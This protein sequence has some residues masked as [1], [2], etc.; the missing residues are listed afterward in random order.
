M[1]TSRHADSGLSLIEI[2]VGVSIFTLVFLTLVSSFLALATFGERNRLR[3]EALLLANEEIEKI[4]ALPYDSIG[5]VA[6]LPSGTIPQTQTMTRDGRNFSVRT[7][8]Q[9]VDD[10]ADGEGAGDTLA[11]DYKRIK[12]EVSYD[13]RGLTQAFSLVTTIAPKSQESLAGAGILRIVVNDANNNPLG[14]AQVHVRNTTV[15]TSVDVTT[16]TNASGVVSFPGAWAGSGYEVTV[17]KSGY[18]TAQTYT[19]TTTNPNPSPSPFTVAENSTTEVYFKIDRVST[20][21][22]FARSWPVRGRLYDDF[23][24]SAQIATSTDVQV[25][26]GALTLAGAPGSYSVSGTVYSTSL[27]PAS[28]G[29]WV[30]MSASTSLPANTSSTYTLQY[31]SGGGVFLPIPDAD[32]PG[33]GAGFTSTPIDLGDLNT[34]T[35]TSLRIAATLRTTDMSVTPSIDEWVLSYL[36]PDAPVTGA[37]VAI[38]GAKTIGTD[39]G[40]GSIYKYNQTLTTNGLGNITLNSMEFDSYTITPQGYTVA[41]GCPSLPLV[42]EPDTSVTQY[43]T[44]ESAT[45]HAYQVTIVNPLG[46]VV[47]RAEV[48]IRHGGTDVTRVTGPCGIAYFP[49]LTADIYTVDVRAAGLQS[50]STTRAISGLT[51]DTVALTN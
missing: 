12:I 29:E 27:T 24:S 28:L 9:Y 32:L 34:S 40:G 47:P 7:F 39:S 41:E 36:E 23:S 38:R 4:R 42:L 1:T 26:G 45:A 10:V 22:L 46:G 50:T 8:I 17:S 5:T 6:G 33:N 30:L 51:Q 15:A 14:L 21:S 13:F 18:S 49:N 43:L 37:S 44:L 31:D 3:A 25:D 48:R 16:F 19:S 11:A 35:Y 20:V 2:V